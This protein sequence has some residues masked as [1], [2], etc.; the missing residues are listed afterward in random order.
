MEPFAVWLCCSQNLHRAYTEEDIKKLLRTKK[1]LKVRK[2]PTLKIS[3]DHTQDFQ[4]HIQDFQ[5]HTQDFQDHTQ[6]FKDHTQDFQDHTQD[7]Q[8]HTL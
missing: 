5:D 8:G 7:F 1:R 4:D 6:D 3:I 2:L